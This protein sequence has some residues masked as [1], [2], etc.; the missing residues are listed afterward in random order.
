MRVKQVAP[1]RLKSEFEKASIEYKKQNQGKQRAYN[2][3]TDEVRKVEGLAKTRTSYKKSLDG[4]SQ[5]ALDIQAGKD[6][7]EWAEGDDC[8]IKKA[9]RSK[10]DWVKKLRTVKKEFIQYEV[11]LTT[12]TPGKV[13]HEEGE[14]CQLATRFDMM[15]RAVEEES[16]LLG[17]QVRIFQVFWQTLR[18]LPEIQR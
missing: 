6:N 18:V 11:L 17:I 15:K 12:R 5:L 10:V 14:L 8:E 13:S 9:I 16:F 4:C 2:T 1:I 7:G 3:K